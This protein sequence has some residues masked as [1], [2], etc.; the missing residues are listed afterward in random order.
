M[1]TPQITITV[2]LFI[3][4]ILFA[5]GKYRH[6][7]VAIFC[8]VMAVV[9]GVVP[10]EDAFTGFGHAAVITVAAVLI[11]SHAL[12]NAGVVNVIASYLTP[13]TDNIYIH[14]ASLTAVVTVASAFMNNVGA[15]ALML[16]V[17]IATANQA[18]RSPALVLM[19][20]AFGSI[21]GGMTTLIGTPPNIIIASY[22]AEVSGE[23]FSM[24]DF[25]PVGFFVALIGL[26]FITLIGWRFIPTDRSS[27]DG[28]ALFE[29]SHYLT[30]IEIKP[31]SALVGELLKDNEIFGS[32]Q[33]DVVGMAQKNGFARPIPLQ[34][35]FSEEDILLVQGD[36]SHLQQIVE[37]NGLEL[38]T[39]ASSNFIQ[40]Q[41]DN[42]IM[43]EGVVGQTSPLIDRSVEYLRIQ[44]KRTMALVGIARNGEVIKT[45][46]KRQRF[47]AGDVLL[48]F[49]D[50]DSIDEQ[51]QNLGLWPLAKRPLSLNRQRK[52][53]PALLVFAG[54]IAMGVAGFVTLPIAFLIAIG[55]FILMK[56]ISVREIYDEIDWPVIVLLGSMIPVGRALES[57]GTTNWMANAIL[58]VTE[59]LPAVALL[60]MILV[61]TMFLSDIINNAATALVMAPIGVAIATSLGVSSDAFLMAVAVGA[62]CAF[63][64]PIGHQ[65][66]TL[67]M[68]PGGYHFGDYW[69]MGLPLEIII[70]AVSVPI[71]LIVWPL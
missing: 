10:S 60:T 68:G 25:S 46:L 64:T 41:S 8:L 70:V 20:L 58:Q 45:R 51:F 15:L 34:Y 5:W 32:D 13:F 42:E 43:L 26:A 44:A 56:I 17:A 35:R 54:A 23:A 67:V 29:I 2:I 11:I 12:K 59:G 71:L 36:P 47:K 7:I 33:V 61:V 19:P 37:E 28:T 52:V 49:G 55:I 63:L 39:T 6:D 69:R 62:S 30:E 65:S 9:A 57:T 22:R 24:F 21:L 3:T 50:A 48:V 31:G 1:T 53:I 40:P 16:P 4:L 18:N 14:I 38:L 66:N 27:K